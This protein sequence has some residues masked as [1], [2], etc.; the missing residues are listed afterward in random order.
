[1]TDAAAVI[2]LT[3]DDAPA[4]R[5]TARA[6]KRART[7][8]GAPSA[9]EVITLDDSPSPPKGKPQRAMARR[10][11]RA[12]SDA[13]TVPSPETRPPTPSVRAAAA[14]RRNRCRTS[15]RPGTRRGARR[16]VPSARCRL[17]C[18][19]DLRPPWLR[20]AAHHDGARDDGRSPPGFVCLPSRRG[21]LALSLSRLVAPPLTAAAAP[22]RSTRRWR[23]RW[24]LARRRAAG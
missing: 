9:A 7:S 19:D 12:R 16:R 11:W 20:R 21:L 18:R 1:M 23:V 22:G 13:Q 8:G 6:A 3:S 4:A 15:C 2:D 14:R 24:R 10:V 17:L 5:R